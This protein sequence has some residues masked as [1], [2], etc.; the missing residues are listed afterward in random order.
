M[1][2]KTFGLH[3]GE[4]TWDWR[5]KHSEEPDDHMEKNGVGKACSTYGREGRCIQNGE[6]E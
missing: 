2:G 4:A 5:R 3:K 6:P 1:L